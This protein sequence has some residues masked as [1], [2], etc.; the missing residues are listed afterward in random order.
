L[1][2]KGLPEAYLAKVAICGGV[3]FW[4]W[5][6]PGG[7]AVGQSDGRSGCKFWMLQDIGVGVNSG[8]LVRRR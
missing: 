2:I 5:R 7:R 8:G 1:K 3:P 4:R 6:V